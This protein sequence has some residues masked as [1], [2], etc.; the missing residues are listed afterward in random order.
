MN[1]KLFN[2]LYTAL[3][4]LVKYHFYDLQVMTWQS[5]LWILDLNDEFWFESPPSKQNKLVIDFSALLRNSSKVGILICTWYLHSENCCDRLQLLSSAEPNK[6]EKI[7]QWSSRCRRGEGKCA[8]PLPLA[9]IFTFSTWC[10]LNEAHPVQL[11][12]SSLNQPLQQHMGFL[13]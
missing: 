6:W 2:S 1:S 7:N 10:C 3:P 4:F 8:A 11:I 12:M 5:Q 9:A 13:K